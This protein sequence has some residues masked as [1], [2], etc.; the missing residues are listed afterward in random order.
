[1]HRS[2]D[3]KIR[4]LLAGLWAAAWVGVAALLLLPMPVSTPDRGD[5]LLHFLLF[6]GMAFGA[7]GFCRRAS[8]LAGLALLTIVCG[9]VLELAQQLVAYR[10]FDL[11]DAAANVLGAISGYALAMI[12]LVL[13]LRPAAAELA[14]DNPR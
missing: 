4:P 3:A 7:I 1:M 6:A 12:V 8:Q 10:S 14:A 2:F 5:L 13:W 9:T 11:A